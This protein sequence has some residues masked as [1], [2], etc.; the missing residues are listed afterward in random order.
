LDF[1]FLKIMELSVPVDLLEFSE[2]RS[3]QTGGKEK[4]GVWFR[5]IVKRGGKEQERWPT[6]DVIRFDLPTQEGKPMF[7]G[8]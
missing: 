4:K 5:L 3:T 7:W 1:S 8:V 6:V 2:S